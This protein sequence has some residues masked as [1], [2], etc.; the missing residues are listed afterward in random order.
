MGRAEA[1]ARLG[2]VTR[3]PGGD[4]DLPPTPARGRQRLPADTAREVSCR[5]V[6]TVAAAG[7]MVCG[8]RCPPLLTSLQP[9]KWVPK[10]PDR[11]GCGKVESHPRAAEEDH[12]DSGLPG[13]PRL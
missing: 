13:V 10:T 3:L 1:A 7:R 6:P 2:A 12:T 5:L 8:P 4:S 11:G 9:L